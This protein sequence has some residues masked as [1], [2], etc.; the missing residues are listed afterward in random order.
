MLLQCITIEDQ[1]YRQHIRSVDFIKRYIFP[2]S[3]IFSVTAITDSATKGTDM[4][5]VHL[6]DITRHYARTL[7]MWRKRFFERID[8]VRRLGYPESFIRMWEFYLSY[9]EASFTERYNGD[10]Q[11]LFTKPFSRIDP[12]LPPLGK[13]N[14]S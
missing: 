10:V 3:C 2:G 13:A 11:M 7:R 8:D 9:C 6:E 12:I 14:Q 1:V 4:R 5:L